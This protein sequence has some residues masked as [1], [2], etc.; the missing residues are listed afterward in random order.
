MSRLRSTLPAFVAMVIA[1]GLLASAHAGEPSPLLAVDANWNALRLKGDAVAL[2]ALLS[3][4]WLLTHSDGRTQTKAEYL[5]ELGTRTRTNQAITNE[6][7]ALRTYG[8]TAVVTGVSV[9]SGITNGQPWNGRFRFT[10]VWVMHGGQ[11]R[12]VAS[13]SSRVAAAP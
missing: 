1:T 2:E 11:W 9:Q 7:V 10:R 8:D 5:T 6:D 12:M 3:D 13:H 4:D